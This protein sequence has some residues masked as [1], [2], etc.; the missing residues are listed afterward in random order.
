METTQTRMIVRR[1]TWR[2]TYLGYILR[3]VN[4]HACAVSSKVKIKCLTSIHFYLSIC[5][6]VM[7]GGFQLL[8]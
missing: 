8:C 3:T 4:I 7:L 6:L 1:I 5:I 2:R